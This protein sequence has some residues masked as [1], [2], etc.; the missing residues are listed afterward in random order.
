MKMYL[1]SNNE[2][3]RSSRLSEVDG[4]HDRQTDR[5]DEAHY[6]PHCG[7]CDESIVRGCVV[8]TMYDQSLVSESQVMTDH[9]GS[10]AGRLSTDSL[11]TLCYHCDDDAD[12]RLSSSSYYSLLVNVKLSHWSSSVVSQWS[13]VD[14]Q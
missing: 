12:N 13:S 3:C 4:E 9:P 8:A 6:W 11:W 1:H 7:W 10:Q 5:R 2:V 14:A